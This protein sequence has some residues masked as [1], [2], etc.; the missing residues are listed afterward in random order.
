MCKGSNVEP[1][2]CNLKVSVERGRGE[3]PIADRVCAVGP[4][5]CA[6]DLLV[7]FGGGVLVLVPLACLWAGYCL[8][9]GFVLAVLVLALV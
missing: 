6:D 2:P 9:V 3:S 1:A 7:V 8:M 5:G 4:I